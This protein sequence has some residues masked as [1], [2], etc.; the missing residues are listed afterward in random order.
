MKG[1]GDINSA[2]LTRKEGMAAQARHR[3]WV[4]SLATSFESREV[5]HEGVGLVRW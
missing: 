3:S 2:F 4:E 5:L 1:T